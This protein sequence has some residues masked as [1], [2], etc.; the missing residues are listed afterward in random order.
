VLVVPPFYWKVGE[1][2]LF[3]H[4]ATVAEAVDIPILV[5][6]IPM[7]IGLD[8]SPSLL[9]RIATQCPNVKGLKDT[10]SEYSHTVNVLREVKPVRP[11]FSVLA[12]LED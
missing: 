8:L 10:V 3:K 6:N 2:A 7:L 9:A 12:G 1:E 4:F 5:Y 11:D